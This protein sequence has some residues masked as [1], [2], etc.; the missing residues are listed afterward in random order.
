MTSLLSLTSLVLA[1]S[2]GLGLVQVIRGPSIEER[3]MG[4]Q[5]MGTTGVGLLLLL[6]FLLGMPASFDVAMVLALLA[7]VATVA[8]TRHQKSAQPRHD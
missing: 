2:L 5:L 7:A 4:V 3:M 8:L 6:G 1:I